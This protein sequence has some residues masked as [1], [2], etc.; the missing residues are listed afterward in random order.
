MKYATSP[1]TIQTDML[2][3]VRIVLSEKTKNAENLL[4]ESPRQAVLGTARSVTTIE[5][6]GYVIIDFGEEIQGGI[7]ITNNSCSKTDE[8]IARFVSSGR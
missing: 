5:K 4:T 8:G 7:V 1:Y 3:P 6:G 2:L